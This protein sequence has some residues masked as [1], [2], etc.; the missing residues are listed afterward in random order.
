MGAG[1]PAKSGLHRYVFLLYKQN[2][3]IQVEKFN[4]MGMNRASFL[5]REF[6]NNNDLGQPV[7]VVAYQAQTESN[8]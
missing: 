8:H 4:D 7:A 3:P 1:P 6:A 5:L 2:G